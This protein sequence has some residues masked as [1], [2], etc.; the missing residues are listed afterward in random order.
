M[1]T[2]SDRLG[3][4]F[5]V[6]SVAQSF[7]ID[8]FVNIIK[9]REEILYRTVLPSQAAGMAHIAGQEIS[10]DLNLSVTDRSTSLAA[11]RI[12][13]GN[14]TTI[15]NSITFTIDTENFVV[16]DE[17][18]SI[19][20]T[21]DAIPLFYK[22]ILSDDNVPRDLDGD[23]DTGVS[24]LSVQFLDALLQPV[25]TA[26]IKI[27]STKGIIYNNLLSEYTSTSE[28]T[29]YY[30]Q[31]IINDNSEV[32]T[33]IDLLDNTT[34]Y[35]LAS[36]IDLTPTL[37][38]KAD[39][40]K[41][42]LIE[43]LSGSY[44]VTLP[45]LGTYSFKPTASAR[46]RVLPPVT[47]SSED[48]WNVRVTNG[49]F[50]TNISSILYK[51]HI[52]EFLSQSFSPEP[53]L[54][55]SASEESTILSNSLIKLDKELIVQR[56]TESLFII[57]LIYDADNNGIAAFSTNPS[58]TGDVAGNGQIYRLWSYTSRTGIRSI[59]H[60]TGFVQ[61][62][63]IKLKSTY[64]VVSTYIYEEANYEVTLLNFN[65]ISNSSALQ[66]RISLFIDPDTL[67]TEKLQTL[68]YLKSDQTGKIIESNWSRF[69][70]DTSLLDDAELLY[71]ERYPDFLQTSDPLESDYL[72]PTTHIFIDEFTTES[73]GVFLVLGDVTTAEIFGPE[74]VEITDSRVRG[75]GVIKDLIDDAVAI[76]P[77]A[78][79]NWDIGY[80]DGQPYPGNASYMVEVPVEILNEAGGIFR[81]NEIQDTI[82]RHTGTGIYTVSRAYGV[83]VDYISFVAGDSI[84]LKWQ[85][86]GSEDYSEIVA[87]DT[88]GHE[89]EVI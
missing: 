80:W 61:V 44:T 84:T 29:I 85:G 56:E 37:Q 22:H 70:N 78:R 82:N 4:K 7:D 67:Y 6:S 14:I 3:H 15:S 87:D 46:I 47:S 13:E 27:D 23:L 74:S 31:Y 9:R 60:R 11:N 73:S 36:F 34:T 89:F 19:T 26:E 25:K 28:Y 41:V 79:W 42:Y 43:E 35:K 51:Y 21:I 86:Y 76:A 55:P 18:T 39:G 5:T 54:K 52:A 72:S 16:T 8:S 20:S 48:V 66:T 65:P 30:V 53:P 75:G 57:M 38:I 2:T 17:Y 50:F 49:K 10:S 69:D 40:R 24:I 45:A 59:D 77:E 12:R 1:P 81:Q 33:F 83:E 64:K 88:I 71:Y 62:E 32:K 68:Y 58:V 63:G